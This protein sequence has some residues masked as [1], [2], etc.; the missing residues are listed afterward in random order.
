MTTTTPEF[1]SQEWL[2]R[3]QGSYATFVTALEQSSF[4]PRLVNAAETSAAVSVQFS[5]LLVELMRGIVNGPFEAN[6]ADIQAGLDYLRET[7]E[8]TQTELA[9]IDIALI[10][11]KLSGIYTLGTYQTPSTNLT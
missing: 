1:G 10:A 4:Y 11:S 6:E 3:R 7:I 5:R 9:E 8:L 2:M